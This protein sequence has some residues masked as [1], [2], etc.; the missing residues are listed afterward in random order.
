VTDSYKEGCLKA[1]RKREG[2]VDQKEKSGAKKKKIDKPWVAYTCWTFQ[3]LMPKSKEKSIYPLGKWA[4]ED[5]AIAYVEKQRR[6]YNGLMSG[7]RFWV[8]NVSGR[9]DGD[10]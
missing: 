5:Q 7:D 2:V 1:K 10:R 4:T 3:I 6:I 8:V 9:N